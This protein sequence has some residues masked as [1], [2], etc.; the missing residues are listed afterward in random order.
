M[1]LLSNAPMRAETV[2]RR[3]EHIGVPRALYHEVMTS[4][5]EVWQALKARTDP[6]FAGL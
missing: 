2:A 1:A 5:E 3:V 6:F 4:G